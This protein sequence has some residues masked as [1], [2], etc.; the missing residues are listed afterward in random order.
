MNVDVAILGAGPGGYV[1]AIRASQL[2]LKTVIIEKEQLGGVCLNWGCIPTK[3]LLKSAQLIEDIH[4]ANSYGI[5]VEKVTI[6][7]NQIFA[8]SRK[9]AQQ[10]NQGIKALMAKNNIEVIFATGFIT[11]VNTISLKSPNQNESPSP[12]KSINAKH[13]IIATG[14]S[15]KLMPNLD[16]E[17]N[18]IWTYKKAMLP[19]FVPSSLVIIGS[20]AIGM[21]FA[22]FY[23]A[24]GTKVCVIE[25]K[26]YILPMEDKE[27]SKTAQQL[28]EKKGIQFFTS[29]HDADIQSDEN[30][31]TI[32][33]THKGKKI[34]KVVDAL[35]TA[36]GITPNTQGIGLEN[37]K[38]QKDVRDHIITDEY[39]QTHEPSIMAIGDVTKGPWLAHKA[40]HEALLAIEKIAG[41]NPHCINY[42]NIP[43]CTYSLPQVAS[44]GLTEEQAKEKGYKLRIGQFPFK[45]SGK[46]QAL[47]ET[48]GLAKLIFDDETGE[49]LGAHLIGSEVTELIYG[50]CIAKQSELSEKE[51]LSTIFPHP[52]LSESILE[53]TLHAFDLPLHI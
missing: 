47:G 22:S 16:Y 3:A 26:E 23:N 14:A 6:D 51:I 24:L 36:T 4:H 7:T 15:P 5:S 50:L 52:T 25:L 44:V 17:N 46:A 2:G 33:F 13:I 48:S 35:L 37:T 28:F 21:E 45:A 43:G 38:V 40:S 9:V 19:S 11:D 8:R 27:I 20:G 32:T 31:V 34:E 10:L 53:S 29:V 12:L 1:A 30:G 49:L 39:C 18:R 42:N 41:R